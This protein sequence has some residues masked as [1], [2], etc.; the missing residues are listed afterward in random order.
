M[1]LQINKPDY[2]DPERTKLEGKKRSK[3]VPARK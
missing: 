2:S 3:F 1:Y